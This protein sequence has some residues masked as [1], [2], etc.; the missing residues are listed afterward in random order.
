M[1][2]AYFDESQSDTRLFMAGFVSSDEKW[3][4]F[5]VAW[6]KELDAP[7]AI[8]FFHMSEVLRQQGGV[9]A[10]IP[11]D[12][13]LRKV[14]RLIG[15]IND[16]VGADSDMDFNVSMNLAEYDRRLKPILNFHKKLKKHDHPYL[17]LF[18]V[19]VLEGLSSLRAATGL[20]ESVRFIFD[21]HGLFDK[22]SS[23][24]E[25]F[26]KFDSFEEAHGLS[27]RGKRR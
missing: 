25:R 1:Q 21:V 20:K 19:G 11:M 2:T 8:P 18:S 16:T 15:V 3:E 4:E 13:R 10:K 5:S 22:A 12:Q 27:S 7:P 17:W 24:F 23:R 14:E 9:F 26:R 6:R